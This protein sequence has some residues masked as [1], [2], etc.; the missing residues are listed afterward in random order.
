MLVYDLLRQDA[1]DLRRQK[2]RSHNPW[3][4]FCRSVGWYYYSISLVLEIL[5]NL[6]FNLDL[7][8]Q[9]H[10]VLIVILMITYVGEYINIVAL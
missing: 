8:G 2:S 3:D 5:Q 1:G 7:Q 10:I 4:D 9:G 6:C